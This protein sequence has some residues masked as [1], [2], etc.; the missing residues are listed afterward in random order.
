M[1]LEFGCK[2]ASVI[3]IFIHIELL[4]ITVSS[5]STIDYVW[6]SGLPGAPLSFQLPFL[7]SSCPFASMITSLA[8]RPIRA[9]DIV[10]FNTGSDGVSD[11]CFVV[12]IDSFYCTA[13]LVTGTVLR[14]SA[15]ATA[16]I[17]RRVYEV[18]CTS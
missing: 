18:D 4:S 17:G 7:Y 11:L 6:I 9:A 16:S 2:F 10:W 15:Q 3:E 14:V 1:K 13:N 12:R 8:V 5:R